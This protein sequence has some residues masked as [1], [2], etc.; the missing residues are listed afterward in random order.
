LFSK[1]ILSDC[2]VN[3]DKKISVDAYKEL[4]FGR[5]WFQYPD[6]VEEMMRIRDMWLVDSMHLNENNANVDLLYYK[7]FNAIVRADISFNPYYWDITD[8]FV[9]KYFPCYTTPT[10]PAN[11]ELIEEA[12]FVL[13]E[14]YTAIDKEDLSNKTFL[15]KN[16]TNCYRKEFIKNLYRNAEIKIIHLTR[17]PAATINGL[18][19]G[20]LHHG[21]FSF[22]LPEIELEIDGYSKP[23]G[24]WHGKHFWNF[25]MPNNWLNLIDK[26]LVD[27]CAEQWFQAHKAILNSWYPEYKDNLLIVK[28]EDFLNEDS[29]ERVIKDVELFLN[30]GRMTKLSKG[31][32]DELPHVMATK[33]PR[34]Q[35]W[36]DRED[37]IIDCL[38]SNPHIEDTAYQ[39]GYGDIDKWT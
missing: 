39:L 29:R 36:R 28:L 15:I 35:R 32:K 7:L 5:L 21:F 19:D 37:V 6:C 22:F 33:K 24:T 9:D 16:P 20:W 8:D 30:S 18:M 23:N 2:C 14:R 1:E 17:N 13:A 12:P 3:G 38:S 31:G 10:V 34:P 27:V 4:I 25:D 11:L 26:P